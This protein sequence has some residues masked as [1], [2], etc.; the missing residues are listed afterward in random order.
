MLEKQVTYPFD[1]KDL[2]HPKIKN[3]ILF[4]VYISSLKK[5]ISDSGEMNKKDREFIREQFAQIYVRILRVA[6]CFHHSS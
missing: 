1:Q 4:E 2:P 6:K 5:Y 3:Q